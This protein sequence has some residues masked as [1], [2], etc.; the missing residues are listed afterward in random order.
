MH[1]KYSRPQGQFLWG[2]GQMPRGQKEWGRG[3]MIWPRGYMGLEALTSLSSWSSWIWNFKQIMLTN[4]H[5]FSLADGTARRAASY[6]IVLYTEV[7]AQCDKL[8]KVVGRT[9]IV[10]STVNTVQPTTVANLR[11]N[12][13]TWTRPDPR[14][15]CRRPARTQRSFSETRAAKKVCAGPVGPV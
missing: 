10:A 1:C 15:L 13:T 3:W 12:S 9:S 7:D 2:W 4:N 14:G 6:S 5:C 11:L 8:A